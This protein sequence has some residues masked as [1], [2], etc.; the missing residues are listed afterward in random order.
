MKLNSIWKLFNVW[1]INPSF[2]AEVVWSSRLK[3]KKMKFRITYREHLQDLLLRT[4]FVRSTKINGLIR[5]LSLLL[6]IYYFRASFFIRFIK[7]IIEK[8]IE[9]INYLYTLLVISIIF[10]AN[11]VYTI[12]SF[13]ACTRTISLDFLQCIFSLEMKFH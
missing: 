8:N 9:E 4:I 1:T 2:L 7:C 13:Y 3:H 10:W 11:V 5:K 6:D 12:F